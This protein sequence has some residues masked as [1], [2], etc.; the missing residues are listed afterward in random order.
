ME[1]NG[2][3]EYWNSG[4]PQYTVIH[5]QN[6]SIECNSIGVPEWLLRLEYM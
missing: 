3:M 5:Y 2:G 6:V 1:W 4:M